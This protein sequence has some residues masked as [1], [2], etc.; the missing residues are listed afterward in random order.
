[1]Q[2]VLIDKPA[3]STPQSPATVDH[4]E[5]GDSGR[6]EL[7]G[8]FGQVLASTQAAFGARIDAMVKGIV[9]DGRELQASRSDPRTRR[10]AKLNESAD[11]VRT[12]RRDALREAADD[13]EYDSKQ[14]MKTRTR[15]K[16]LDRS[17]QGNEGRFTRVRLPSKKEVTPRATGREQSSPAASPPEGRPDVRAASRDAPRP[18]PPVS[19]SAD[20]TQ[21]TQTAKPVFAADAATSASAMASTGPAA[22]ASNVTEVSSA[23]Q[24]IGEILGAKP[25]G[26]RSG[27]AQSPA[28]AADTK[29][30]AERGAEVK[31]N[32][33]V[34]HRPPSRAASSDAARLAGR[35]AFQRLVRALRLNVGSRES[36]ARLH[37]R[38]PELGRVRIDV[39]M[40]DQRMNLLIRTETPEARALLETR[41]NGLREALA[42]HGVV[43]ERLDLPLP[44]P[45]HPDGMP[46]ADQDASEH[47]PDGSAM[48]PR[49]N[50]GR[51]TG[52]H[53]AP[54]ND[55]LPPALNLAEVAGAAGDL[56]LDIRV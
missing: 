23:A 44:P 40:V 34:P 36:T 27:G 15:T 46:P 7:S 5:A 12:E 6:E 33:T 29:G 39:R 1:M 38:P 4:R 19:S 13:R 16:V 24:Q 48:N 26:A 35:A 20:A 31:T 17:T 49:N 21:S 37:L 25:I 50:D 30:Q 8:L 54:E 56:R 47:R 10:M 18:V 11:Q 3:T 45:G 9:P 32:S 43:V 28:V 51:Q 55:D 14:R 22:P 52:Q 42:H 2:S 53:G 41:V